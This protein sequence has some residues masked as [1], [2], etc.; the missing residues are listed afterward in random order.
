MLTRNKTYFITK[1]SEGLKQMTYDDFISSVTRGFE[2]RIRLDKNIFIDI[3]T[4]NDKTSVICYD[5]VFE[6]ETINICDKEFLKTDIEKL[7]V[8]KYMTFKELFQSKMFEIV[9]MH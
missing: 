7:E 1:E 4:L 5:L 6:N 8:Y 3:F 2:F 9:K